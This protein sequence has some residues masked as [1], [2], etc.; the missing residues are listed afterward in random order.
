MYFQS[1]ELP[2][3]IPS[4]MLTQVGSPKGRLHSDLLCNAFVLAQATGTLL[5]QKAWAAGDRAAASLC[6]AYLPCS[7]ALKH[8]RS[9]TVRSRQRA[10][11]AM[12]NPLG[13][14]STTSFILE[15]SALLSTPLGWWHSVSTRCAAEPC[16][17]P[18]APVLC[19]ASQHQG[20]SAGRAVAQRFLQ[21]V[22]HCS[23]KNSAF[24]V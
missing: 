23:G 9:V 3:P 18:R 5:P 21:I 20:Q 10:V 14:S 2:C 7:A 17:S 6:C 22:K 11:I 15:G 19:G 12:L 13:R 4:Y 24:E 8:P 1:E 16:L